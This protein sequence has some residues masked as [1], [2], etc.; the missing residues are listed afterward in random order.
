MGCSFLFLP[1]S[2]HLHSFEPLESCKGICIHLHTFLLSVLHINLVQYYFTLPGHHKT[3]KMMTREK[4][5]GRV[6]LRAWLPNLHILL[7]NLDSFS[8]QLL[9]LNIGCFSGGTSWLIL[10][11]HHQDRSQSQASITNSCSDAW[12]NNNRVSGLQV[13]SPNLVHLLQVQFIC[14]EPWKLITEIPQVYTENWR[15][16]RKVS[17]F[18]TWDHPMYW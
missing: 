11:I 4:K 9:K 3:G 8:H 15:V 6:K 1:E 10:H 13:T 12:Q 7:L 18:Q 5:R 2:C 14:D 17:G 16:Q